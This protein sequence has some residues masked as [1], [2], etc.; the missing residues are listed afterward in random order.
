MYEFIALSCAHCHALLFD[1]PLHYVLF[2][3]NPTLLRRS[4]NPTLQ[5]AHFVENCFDLLR[6]LVYQNCVVCSYPC[7]CN[8]KLPFSQLHFPSFLLYT[9]AYLVVCSN[10]HRLQKH[11][12]HT[13]CLLLFHIYG[14]I[15]CSQ[16]PS[17]S[18]LCSC[19][20]NP[21]RIC[22]TSSVLVAESS[23][24]FTSSRFRALIVGNSVILNSHFP[25]S[26]ASLFA[27]THLP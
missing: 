21:A 14:L 17:T 15:A 20:L 18:L 1:S 7:G 5:L 26:P 3:A 23:V 6:N 24:V 2:T 25:Q 27:P 12:R 19:W 22:S 10:L 8:H 13:N 4:R 11:I 9:Y 16:I